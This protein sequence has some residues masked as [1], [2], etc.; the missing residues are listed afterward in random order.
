MLYLGFSLY[1][2]TLF[3]NKSPWY[4]NSLT[5]IAVPTVHDM[6]HMYDRLTTFRA[7]ITGI[8]QMV[9]WLL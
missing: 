3:M 5:G 6:R 7:G 2:V 1:T 9:D 4:L 8:M